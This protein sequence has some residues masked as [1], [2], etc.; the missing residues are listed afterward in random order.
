[1]IANNYGYDVT[2]IN[3]SNG[4]RTSNKNR[5]SNN[6][7]KPS[8]KKLKKLSDNEI[9]KVVALVTDKYNIFSVIDGTKH[10][11]ALALGGYFT[12][13]IS[14]I[15]SMK[16]ATGIVKKV[17]SGL[18]KDSEAFKNDIVKNYVRDVEEKTGLPTLIEYI[19]ESDPDFNTTK[20]SE[21]LEL[22]CNS[23]FSKRKVATATIDKTKVPV[24]LYENDFQKWLKYEGI[25]EGIDLT[26][27][28]NTLI[29]SF[30]YSKT[31]KEIDS[32]KFKFNNNYIEITKF[33]ELVEFLEE[34]LVEL[35]KTFEKQLRRS[36]KSLDKSITKPKVI[37][38][39]ISNPVEE[40]L[41]E[42]VLIF[43]VNENT[44]LQQSEEKG[45]VEITTTEK[46]IKTKPIANVVITDVEIILDSLEILEPV[47]NVTYYNKTFNKEETV[48]Y[49]TKRQLTEEFIKAN[50]FYSSTKENVETVLNSFIIDGTKEGR[51]ATITEAYLEGF[52]LINNHV[53]SNTKLN[54][55]KK[56]TKEEVA[57]AITLLN[58]IMK[59]RTE[60]GRKNDSS[61]YRF[62]LWNPFSYVLKQLGY[63]KANYS[64]ILIGKSQTNKTGATNIG[65][66]FYL[67][68]EEETSG[69][70]V[71]VLGS[72]IGE[73]SFL[74][75]FDECSH[76]FK[77]PE[78]LNVMKRLIY[79]FT[80][81]ATKD[82][83]DNTKIDVFNAIGLAMFILNE[84]I[85]FKDFITNRY[86]IIYY[87]G[88][89]YL[90]NEAIAE[91]NKN[92]VPESNETILKKLAVIG[93]VF[94]E[95]LIAII[96]DPTE[97]S[98]LFNIEETTIDI[99]KEIQAEAE[100]DFLPEML[101]ETESSTKFNYDVI[102]ELRK[103]LNIEFKKRIRKT[104]NYYIPSDFIQSARNSNFNFL[105][106][107]SKKQMFLIKFSN[108]QKFI[109]EGLS[110]V[111]L[112]LNE[113]LDYLDL[114]E[115]L[116]EEAKKD[117][118]T[119]ETFIKKANRI[120]NKVHNGFYLDVEDLA[121][122]VF[123]I[124]LS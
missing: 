74:S 24:Y 70:T 93:K 87:S 68:N 40:D 34:E 28:F 72:K 106:Y 22:I 57:E 109:N 38:K 41:P 84:R 81:R 49:L 21:E 27:N 115:I 111:N 92:Y 43:G 83:T 79:E 118:K 8:N 101:E 60:E 13:H 69:S 64:L 78:A 107:D 1:M 36:I 90:T 76:L 75:V 85:T 3:K 120:G 4:K 44:Y 37:E 32:F 67:H 65:R 53:V 18:F 122:K 46:G 56:P 30:M 116:K 6:G 20:F 89:S 86:K 88:N 110:D 11:G 50:V 39:D 105:I 14:K 99:L 9:A 45:I 119:Y 102:E 26:L 124:Q 63:S 25:L 2:L 104:D 17:P 33:K 12:K 47:Y 52:F 15:S 19:E 35:P 94:S 123:N 58:E 71:S 16:I 96:E 97:R 100:V 121:T 77:L 48:K 5:S 82:R 10:Y 103:F 31:G 80:A 114:T 91:F 42:D 98:R 113:I 62:M 7:R 95:K 112:E 61:V 51:I 59:D 29:G 66:L 54:N 55:L 108:F 73:N 23:N 117:N